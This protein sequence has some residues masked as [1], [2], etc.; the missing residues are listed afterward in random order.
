MNLFFV[1]VNLALRVKDSPLFH[2]VVENIDGGRGAV[3][4][5]GR[6]GGPPL[7]RARVHRGG[8]RHPSP[9]PLPSPNQVYIDLTSMNV[10]WVARKVC[11]FYFHVYCIFR[12]SAVGYSMLY[13]LTTMPIT[14]VY[15]TAD[16]YTCAI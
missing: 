10:I 2:I 4:G 14:F 3:R 5:G 6:E 11:L 9:H 13:T 12:Q 15:R 16:V 1:K 8:R 7:G